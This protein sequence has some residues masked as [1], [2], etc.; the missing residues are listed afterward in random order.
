MAR[1]SITVTLALIIG[2][3]ISFF[4]T[5]FGGI[6]MHA[7]MA[8]TNLIAT[9]GMDSI[10]AEYHR[11]LLNQYDLFYIDSSYGNETGSIDQVAVHLRSMMDKN[12]TLPS[13]YWYLSN[14]DFMGLSVAAIVPTTYHIASDYGGDSI[15]EQAISYTKDR[16]G[17]GIA[18]TILGELEIFQEYELG[19]RNIQQEQKELA[20]EASVEL[21]PEY[22][23]EIID[24][25]TLLSAELG[26]VSQAEIV[27]AN[28][29]RYRTLQTGFYE[30]DQIPLEEGGVESMT[31]EVI[32]GEYLLDHCSYYGNELDKSHLK[33]QIEYLIAG[34][35]SD[36]S[37]LNAVL[38]G[39]IA[40]R[41]V[42]NYIYLLKDAQKSNLVGT[43]A[44]GIA[45]LLKMPDLE[46]PIKYLLLGVWA[47]YES[48]LDVKALVK[49]EK[50]PFLKTDDTWRSGF[51]DGMEFS[52]NSVIESGQSYEDYLR[53]LLLLTNAD[54][55]LYRFMDIIETDIRATTD[56]AT[57]QLDHCM[58][59]V[60]MEITFASQVGYGRSWTKE[61]S[62]D[63]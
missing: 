28:T 4:F 21:P 42:S 54:T 18:E 19:T 47:T 6:Q 22:E 29:V 38:L 49:G 52:E 44:L 62:Y 8:R 25:I 34:N 50:V 15:K 57:F 40:I 11:E 30:E 58:D 23:I 3:L 56:I 16:I 13:S 53:M 45:L 1:G 36:E 41:E 37:N 59:T 55:K 35:S 17:I 10:M 7:V 2:I 24:M 20:T 60:T 9:M 46:K 61:Y 43:V 12:V 63:T 26:T 39:L 27:I 33:Y 31:E 32:F 5:I 48:V 14:Y 51:S